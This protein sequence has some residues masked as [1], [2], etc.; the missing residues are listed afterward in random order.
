MLLWTGL[1][2]LK[3]RNNYN[4]LLGCASIDTVNPAVAYAFYRRFKEMGLHNRD[5]QLQPQSKYFLPEPP[6]ADIEAAS[7]QI[8]DKTPPLIKGYLRLGAKISGPPILDLDFGCAD[9][10][11]WFDFV[12]IDQ[13]YDRHFL[14]GE[15]PK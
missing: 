3:K 12:D 10:P 2:E 15:E 4:Y 13:K 9:L 5:W 11:I 8:A 7:Q 1:A 14:Q 6:E